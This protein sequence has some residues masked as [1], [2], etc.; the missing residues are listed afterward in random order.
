VSPGEWGVTTQ[1]GKTVYVHLLRA[2]DGRVTLPLKAQVAAA[3]LLDGGAR[4]SVARRGDR[5]EITGL[6]PLGESWDQVVELTLR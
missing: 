2:H 5:V 1:K 3:R 4:V 6:P